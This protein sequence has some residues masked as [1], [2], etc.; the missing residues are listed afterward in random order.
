[1]KCLGINVPKET[2][3]LYSENCKILIKEIETNTKTWKN[4]P[5]SWDG[6]FN[7]VKIPMLPNAIYRFSAIHSKLPMA[8][9]ID[10]NE[11]ILKFLRQKRPWRAKVIT[12]KEKW[13]WKNQVGGRS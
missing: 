11:K 3:D 2:K 13:S 7:I 4:I 5:S 1:M 12:E 6:K 10:Q 9:L 8:T